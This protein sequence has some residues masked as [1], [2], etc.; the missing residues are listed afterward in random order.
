MC[1]K[2][3]FLLI[4]LLSPIILLASK[5]DSLLH[6]IDIALDDTSKI[7]LY[8]KL[9]YQQIDTSYDEAAINIEHAENLAKEVGYQ[10]GLAISLYNKGRNL[11]FNN[12]FEPALKIISE[13]LSIFETIENIPSRKVSSLILMGWVTDKMSNYYK[14]LT[15]YK[16]AEA[17]CHEHGLT[18]NLGDIYINIG[19][20]HNLLGDNAKAL[21]FYD[22]A[23]KQYEKDNNKEGL[24]YYYTNIAY[25]QY[26]EK[27]YPEAILNNN[28]AL[29]ITKE[30]ELLRLES[31]ILQNLV[32]IYIETSELDEAEK[33]FPRIQEIDSS[34]GDKNGLAYLSISRAKIAL[35]K[36]AAEKEIG[37][38]LDAYHTGKTS[39]DRELQRLSA[40]LLSEIYLDKGD[41]K[42]AIEQSILTNK[43]KD[44][45]AITEMKFQISNLEHKTEFELGQKDQLI[46]ESELRLSLEKQT[47]IKKA[48]IIPL[49]I[50]SILSFFLYHL[51]KK[52]DANKKALEKKNNTLKKT[53][54]V[55]EL[56]NA[57][58][59]KYI[60]H[61]I[62]LEQ[63]A[64]IASHDFKSPLRTI[65]GFSGLL[66]KELY[67]VANEKQKEHFEIVEKGIS[68]L[69]NL[70][71]DLL[72]FSVE[73]SQDLYI[74][75]MSSSE[76][77][78]EVLEF[79]DH[80]IKES[81]ATI[82]IDVED[83]LL[84]GDK[85]KI[86][87][88][89]QNLISNSI[90]FRRP[91]IPLTINLASKTKEDYIYFSIDD[92]GIG[93]NP[94]YAK[95]IFDKFT[96]LNSKDSYEGTG[97]GLSLCRKY[98]KKHDGKIWLAEKESAGSK[99]IFS[100]SRNL[101]QM[102]SSN[103]VRLF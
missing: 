44:S 11:A 32:L 47:L 94:K 6:L 81:K 77:F 92:N 75:E 80:D 33:L 60:E 34:I 101:T 52:A 74:E 26:L 54:E 91:N 30:L 83:V 9:A 2:K 99:F 28:K 88:V 39:K 41:Y 68:R 10:K 20:I 15:Y 4:L 18:K 35:I 8:N 63:F 16:E 58:L 43:L 62:E 95:S 46:K 38:L 98:I 61:N 87:Q 50:L 67:S 96:Q 22:K 40:A 13:A 12:Q 76:I 64:H 102:E 31:N 27:V 69:D 90:K 29:K 14:A 66:K 49:A 79:L 45:I 57:D 24:G 78:E 100:I 65:S 72:K 25:I 19:R 5:Q 86:K 17:V 103:A 1:P 59:Q 56:K 73:N 21:S 53:E 85:I 93:I 36:G 42:K 37:A 70:I 84:N 97:L 55:L 3:G 48:L 7:L 89:V 23:G 51:Y 82:S 71:E